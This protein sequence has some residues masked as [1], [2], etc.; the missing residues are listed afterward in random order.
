MRSGVL[1]GAITRP[2][3]DDA[4]LLTLLELAVARLSDSKTS[5]LVISHKRSMNRGWA[6]HINKLTEDGQELKGI[7]TGHHQ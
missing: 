3:G 4:L 2:L 6:G 1:R 7:A 5:S